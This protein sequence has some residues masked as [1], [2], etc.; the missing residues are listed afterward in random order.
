[1]KGKVQS[2]F[3]TYV[4]LFFG[5]VLTVFVVLGAILILAPGT[6][7]F[8]ITYFRNNI[9]TNVKYV[10]VDGTDTLLH[11]LPIENIVINK[12]IVNIDD[13]TIENAHYDV[14][15]VNN[16]ETNLFSFIIR[17]TTNGFTTFADNTKSSVGIS[18]DKNT[19]TVTLA[20]KESAGSFYLGKKCSITIETP[21]GYNSANINLILNTNEGNITIGNAVSPVSL[22]SVTAVTKTGYALIN[23]N[24][25]MT[26][27]D[28]S[29]KS[30]KGDVKVYNLNNASMKL[31][32]PNIHL[33][34]LSGKINAGNLAGKVTI[35]SNKSTIKL[36]N[37]EGSLTVDSPKGIIYAGDITEYFTVTEDSKHINMFLGEIHGEVLI[38]QAESSQ[39][40]I[41][42]TY[43]RV[44]IRSKRGHIKIG[45][46]TDEATLET[47]SSNIEFYT[48]SYKAITATT[49]KGKIIANVK[50]LYEEHNLKTKSGSITINLNVNL[51]VTVN[52]KTL[53][54]IK[55]SWDP[56]FTGKN[57]FEA[58]RGNGIWNIYAESENG[59]I[60][61]NEKEVSSI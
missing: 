31:Y 33:E 51:N 56:D 26:G 59:R 46:I 52:A 53:G 54:D 38:A 15:F 27:G 50:T 25:T 49:T 37:V 17:D 44:E 14:N 13:K 47:E 29:L 9:D 24:V 16:P 3:L 18:Y 1:M 5:L 7:I 36:G 55:V 21:A 61:I 58:V 43:D 28:I 11:N 39:V 19:K 41:E 48:T 2:G 42:K 34:S 23:E 30:E 32:K 4:L 57:E 20:Y 22:K 10:N 8:G 12:G 40:E 45:E 60:T 35:K 6:N